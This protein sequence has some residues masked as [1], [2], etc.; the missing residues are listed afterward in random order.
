VSNL[1][2]PRRKM[3]ELLSDTDHLNRKIG[4]FNIRVMNPSVGNGGLFREV[5]AKVEG[6]I[7]LR[8]NESPFNGSEINLTPS[9][10]HLKA[11][12]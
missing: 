1:P 2:L 4:L 8:W 11:V 9:Y 5:L 12:L 10:E 3:W 7:T 6:L